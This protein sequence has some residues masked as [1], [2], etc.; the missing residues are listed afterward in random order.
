MDWV[1][2]GNNSFPKVRNTPQFPR[3]HGAALGLVRLIAVCC[4]G[5]L[6]LVLSEAAHAGWWQKGRAT[7]SDL[8]SAC[9]YQ[10]CSVG[11]PFREHSTYGK[12]AVEMKRGFGGYGFYPSVNPDEIPAQLIISEGI[13]SRNARYLVR[14]L[15]VY[16]SKIFPLE[17]ANL[18]L[19]E[20]AHVQRPG[21]AIPSGGV[22]KSFG[23]LV[24]AANAA[25]PEDFVK[26]GGA[27]HTALGSLD[28]QLMRGQASYRPFS[29]LFRP[30][31]GRGWRVFNQMRGRGGRYRAMDALIDA[32][33]S[34]FQPGVLSE[35]KNALA[36]YDRRVYPLRLYAN[37]DV[38]FRDPEFYAFTL[39]G[40]GVLTATAVH[41][42]EMEQFAT[43]LYDDIT[44]Y[45]G[46]R[47]KYPLNKY[48]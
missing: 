3:F 21:A 43:M 35:L 10:E 23:Q 29:F 38:L 17:D 44:A 39:V 7:L 42:I 47:G 34:E 5:I 36:L 41:A 12:L 9:G 16:N 2:C 25:R 4:I 20:L 33:A 45:I 1:N 19:Q 27:I 22:Y 30:T 18:L 32:G 37:N 13:S 6:S 46:V 31:A 15:E 26:R 11:S 8:L 48:N 28:A 40:A 14:T 24:S